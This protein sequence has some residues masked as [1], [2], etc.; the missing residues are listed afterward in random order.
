[1][2]QKDRK[3]TNNKKNRGKETEKHAHRRK[4]IANKGMSK[5]MN[6]AH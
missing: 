1:M 4:N 6:H 3:K 2:T 5:A